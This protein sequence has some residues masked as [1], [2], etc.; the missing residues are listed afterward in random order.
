MF[1]V[2]LF[3][4]YYEEEEKEQKWIYTGETNEKGY[5]VFKKIE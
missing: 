5:P 1:N 3:S 4:L 2:K